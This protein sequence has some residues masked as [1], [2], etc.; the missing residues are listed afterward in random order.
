MKALINN[1][2][3]RAAI[4][5]RFEVVNGFVVRKADRAI[6]RSLLDVFEKTPVAMWF[7]YEGAV[8]IDDLNMGSMER[9]DDINVIRYLLTNI[10]DGQTEE[11]SISFTKSNSYL[12]SAGQNTS[13]ALAKPE[14]GINLDASHLNIEMRGEGVMAPAGSIEIDL[15][16]FEG[17]TFEII[18]FE[19]IHKDYGEKPAKIIESASAR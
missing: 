10:R 17:F 4:A 14:G 13:P 1:D 11:F 5:D 8:H 2:V 15:E 18:A 3:T 7:K 16:H 9:K 12:D 6:V 19:K